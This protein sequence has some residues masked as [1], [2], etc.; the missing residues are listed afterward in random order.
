MSKIIK[1]VALLLCI[2][3]LTFSQSEDILQPYI[4]K[5]RLLLV[6]ATSD[7]TL[8]YQQQMSIIAKASTGFA[9]RHLIVFSFFENR[10]ISPTHQNLD[11]HTCKKLY[12]K[13]RISKD[14]FTVV[15]IGKDGGEKYRKN[16]ILTSEELF[17]II[18]AMP[19]RKAEMKN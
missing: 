16:T 13:F 6:F 19:M 9:E 2:P 8:D 3:M 5:N 12:E 10:G 15:L 18:D 17:A 14:N 1:T 11:F 7:K 4:W